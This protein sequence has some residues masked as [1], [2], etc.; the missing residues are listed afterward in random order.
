MAD[1]PCKHHK[2][3][4]EIQGKTIQEHTRKDYHPYPEQ[5]GSGGIRVAPIGRT[6]LDMLQ[7]PGY[8]G[9]FSHVL[10]VF[11][12][13]AGDYLPVILKTIDKEGQV[14]DKVRGVYPARAAGTPAFHH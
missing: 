7:E 14:I 3:G 12:E 10:E 11:T 9:G 8:C 1:I 4:G 5:H 13:Y 2:P 6:F